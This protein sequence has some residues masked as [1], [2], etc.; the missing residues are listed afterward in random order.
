MSGIAELG[1][2][3]VMVDGMGT[4]FRSR[5]FENVCYKNLKDAGLPDHIAWIKSAAQK[6]PYMDIDR[7]GIYGCSAGGQESM[8]AVLFHPEFIK[9]H[10]LPVAAMTIV[11][12]RYGGMNNGWVIRLVNNIKKDR[13]LRMLTCSVAR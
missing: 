13:M 5:T 3:V 6:Y 10:I 9:Q 12:I 11:W 2:I 4:S 8:T 1:F 7:V